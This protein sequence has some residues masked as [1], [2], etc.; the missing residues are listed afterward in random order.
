L[1]RGELRL[2]LVGDLAGGLDAD[3][4]VISP[5]TLASNREFSP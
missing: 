1:P 2:F 4:K 3:A 5:P